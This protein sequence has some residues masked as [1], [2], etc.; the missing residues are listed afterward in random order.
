MVVINLFT[1]KYY[2]SLFYLLEIPMVRPFLFRYASGMKP[3]IKR[4][5][6]RTALIRD[7]ASHWQVVCCATGRIANPLPPWSRATVIHSYRLGDEIFC[8]QY[9]RVPTG[10]ERVKNLSLQ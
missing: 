7:H 6:D 3:R 4:R 5:R 1:M 8:I 2:K 10:D 9:L